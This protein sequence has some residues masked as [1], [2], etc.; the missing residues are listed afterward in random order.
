ML[1]DNSRPNSVAQ[2]LGQPRANVRKV[3]PSL[4]V[5]VA[6]CGRNREYKPVWLVQARRWKSAQNAH[7]ACFNSR[8]A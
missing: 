4:Q 5:A 2:F 7:I 6:W 8:F 1:S 3:R